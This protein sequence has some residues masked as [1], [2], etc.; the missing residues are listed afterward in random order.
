MAQRITFD[1][2]V[3]LIT[4]TADRKNKSTA[5]DWN[6]V[7]TVVNDHADIIDAGIGRTGWGAY[8]DTQYPNSGT[9]F[10]LTAD[11]DTI[12]PNNAGVK[13]ETQLPIDITSFVDVIDIGAYEHSRIRGNEGDSIDTLIYFKAVPSTNGQWVDVW[14]DL[15]GEVGQ[16]YRQTFTFPKG[17]G[18]ER[19]IVY[20]LA[21]LYQSATWEANGG[22]IYIRSNA[23]LSI[24][25]IDMNVD[26]THK[27]R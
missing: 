6:E 19:S 17:S 9:A 13:R 4:T 12:F 15:G 14:L 26:R 7:K 25:D 20:T 23:S 11:T 1:T 8:A 3:D 2:K 21:S 10:T 18:Q 22:T 16:I 24:Y 27:A 5:A